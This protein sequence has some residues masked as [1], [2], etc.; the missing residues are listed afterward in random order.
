MATRKATDRFDIATYDACEGWVESAADLTRQEAWALA[1]RLDRKGEVVKVCKAGLGLR[2]V[3]WSCGSS[4]DV[5]EI[6]VREC[7][8]A[9]ERA[10]GIF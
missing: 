3:V 7:L 9:E 2:G 8:R 4:C 10:A 1:L 5:D 6:Y